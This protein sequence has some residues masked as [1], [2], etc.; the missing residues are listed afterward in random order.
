[1]A[2]TKNT[3]KRSSGLA[4]SCSRASKVRRTGGDDTSSTSEDDEATPVF[5]C[6]RSDGKGN[7]KVDE[8]EASKPCG[9]SARAQRAAE[10]TMQDVVLG[11]ITS[12]EVLPLLRQAQRM[13]PTWQKVNFKFFQNWM[14]SLNCFW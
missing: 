9:R 6:N 13:L 11:A 4:E 12:L 10:A 8:N 7:R 14:V 3:S 2:H 5:A 1:M